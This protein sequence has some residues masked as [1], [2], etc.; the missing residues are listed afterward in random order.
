MTFIRLYQQSDGCEMPAGHR[1]LIVISEQMDEQGNWV[2]A[3]TASFTGITQLHR[4]LKALVD[5]GDK[6]VI[7]AST[8]FCGIP[9]RMGFSPLFGEW[10]VL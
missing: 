7:R 10:G 8:S 5:A 4:A 3:R 1:F 9:E 6:V 2:P